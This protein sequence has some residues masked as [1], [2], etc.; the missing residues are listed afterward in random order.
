MFINIS[1]INSKILYF[2]ATWKHICVSE[3]T[4]I[5]RDKHTWVTET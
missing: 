5:K 1:V 4:N 2:I 3:N